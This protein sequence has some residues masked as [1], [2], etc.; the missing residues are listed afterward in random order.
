MKV[1]K[2]QQIPSLQFE[3]ALQDHGTG[4]GYHH[5]WLQ[6]FSQAAVQETKGI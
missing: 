5:I 4:H 3:K 6:D 2:S 1:S